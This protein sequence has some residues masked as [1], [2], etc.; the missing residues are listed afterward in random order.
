VDTAVK[1]NLTVGVLERDS[2][3][4]WDRF[5]EARP[6]GTFFHL[7]GWKNVIEKAFGHTPHYLYAKRDSEL[8][9]V[10]PLFHV[11]SLLF[12]NA[13]ISTP[14][15]TYGGVV[16]ADAAAADELVLAA[17]DLAKDLKVDYLEMRNRDA[18]GRDW[19]TKDLYV[20]F[21]VPLDPD[22]KKNFQSIGGKQRTKVRKGI[23]Q[24]LEVTFDRDTERHF[25]LYAEM[26]RNLGTP[27]FGKRYFRLLKDEFGEQ[28]EILMVTHAGQPVSGMMSFYFRDEMLIEYGGGTAESK[29]LKSNQFLYWALME[30]A[31]ERGMRVFDA[32][33][34]KRGTGS[35]AFKTHW[36]WQPQPLFYEYYLVRAKEVPNYSPTNPKYRYFIE[37]WKRLPLPVTQ[38]VGPMLARNL[39]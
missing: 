1:N 26:V 17:C 3:P 25:K 5:V 37:A 28:C 35:F 10:L 29:T 30:R 23:K 31:C 6:E 38:I 21:R 4:E 13:L 11:K 2:Y 36:R 34:S 16:A 32:G 15:C 12:G 33:R 8:R 19:P 7:S 24:G 18:S 22:P 27:V 9:A 14:F 39:G 20:T